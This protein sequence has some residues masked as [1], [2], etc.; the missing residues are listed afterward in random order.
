MQEDDRNQSRIDKK[1]PTNTER[2]SILE[3]LVAEFSPGKCSATQKW[4]QDFTCTI[5]SNGKS[6]QQHPHSVSW[7]GSSYSGWFKS[8]ADPSWLASSLAFTSSCSFRSFRSRF[9]CGLG[10]EGK[11]ERDSGRE[12]TGPDRRGFRLPAAWP[13]MMVSF[14]TYAAAAAAA[15]GTG[16]EIGFCVTGLPLRHHVCVELDGIPCSKNC[17]VTLRNAILGDVRFSWDERRSAAASGRKSG[18]TII[19]FATASSRTSCEYLL[20]RY[21]LCLF[22]L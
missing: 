1:T 18:K 7:G 15:A 14:C 9:F 19:S 4:N 16:C 22:P 17:I 6:E 21:L 12:T 5:S 2:Y 10:E 3:W 11:K 20:A 8:I 13:K